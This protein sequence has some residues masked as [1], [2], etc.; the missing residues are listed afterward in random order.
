MNATAERLKSTILR[1]DELVRSFDEER[2]ARRSDADWSPKQ[3]IGHLIDSASNNHQRFVRAQFTD[4]LTFPGYDGDRWVEAQ[5][6]Q[7]APWASLVSLWREFNLHLARTIEKIPAD[8]ANA[9]RVQHN[10]DEIAFKTVPKEQP[11]TLSY[12][13]EDYIDH[14]E[15]HLAQIAAR[16]G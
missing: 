3:I 5:D 6:Y 13:M 10:L 14:L 8:V 1:A 12:F 2:A 7:S 9:S 4:H 16:R 11:V 15:H